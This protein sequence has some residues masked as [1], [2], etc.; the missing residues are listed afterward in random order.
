MLPLRSSKR[1]C[2]ELAVSNA[3]SRWNVVQRS[4]I[5]PM[6]KS[7]RVAMMKAISREQR[8]YG[9]QFRS[10]SNTEDFVTKLEGFKRVSLT[11]PKMF[12]RL[13]EKE[14]RQLGRKSEIVYDP[15]VEAKKANE[16]RQRKPK[17]ERMLHELADYFAQRIVFETEEQYRNRIGIGNKHF[18]SAPSD[19]VAHG[20]LK[21]N[22]AD[23]PRFLQAKYITFKGSEL[24]F[25]HQHH[26]LIINRSYEIFK[27]K[28]WRVR[29]IAY[30]DDM[31]FIYVDN[32]HVPY[33]APDSGKKFG[34]AGAM[35]H[36]GSE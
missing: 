16:E 3:S 18:H 34:F 21:Q 10:I 30:C 6:S 20:N 7:Q 27:K 15:Y 35:V 28:L 31:C 33:S 32:R 4:G 26:Q 9:E 5:R 1:F 22:A 24:A 29:D 13:R 12:D 36:R 14:A 2:K 25:W 23:D 19:D 11:S 8:E 17:Q